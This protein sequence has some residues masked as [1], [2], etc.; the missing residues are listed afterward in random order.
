VALVIQLK[1]QWLVAKD[2]KALWME[3]VSEVGYGI[4]DL[5]N[6]V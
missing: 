4:T 3:W 2:V 6:E 5:Q 1:I